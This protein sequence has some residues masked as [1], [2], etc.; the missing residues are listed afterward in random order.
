M[1]I[2]FPQFEALHA[3]ARRERAEAIYQLIVLPIA[4]FFTHAPRAHIAH[5]GPKRR[6]AA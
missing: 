5:Q 4:R 1:R 6:A 2:D 3:R